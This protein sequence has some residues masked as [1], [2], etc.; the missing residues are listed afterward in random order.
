MNLQIRLLT[1]TAK[2]DLAPRIIPDIINTSRGE[3]KGT[4]K[5]HKLKQNERTFWGEHVFGRPVMVELAFVP[6]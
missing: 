1:K 5:E 3:K 6:L 2:C 4:Q